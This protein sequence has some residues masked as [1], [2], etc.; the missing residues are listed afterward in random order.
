MVE[1]AKRCVYGRDVPAGLAQRGERIDH[2][3][4]RAKLPDPS[5]EIDQ[6]ILGAARLRSHGVDLEQAGL[7]VR[8]EL[9]A[10]GPEIPDDLAPR[11]VEAHVEHALAA[12]A[13]R[14]GEDPGDR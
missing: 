14:S 6:M 3:V 12:R 9:D 11:L 5:L 13:G 2:H 1:Q 10:D 4:L 8:F 7:A